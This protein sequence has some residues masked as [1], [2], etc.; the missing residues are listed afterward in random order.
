MHTLSCH[1]IPLEIRKLSFISPSAYE[2]K[3]F[4]HNQALRWL[5]FPRWFP[6]LLKHFLRTQ[7][8]IKSRLWIIC[9]CAFSVSW[10]VTC[11]WMLPRCTLLALC[12]VSLWFSMVTT[13]DTFTEPQVSSNSRMQVSF[14]IYTNY[15]SISFQ[16]PCTFQH[17]NFIKKFCGFRHN[18]FK[19]ENSLLPTKT[20]F[21]MNF[22]ST[23]S[24][25]RWKYFSLKFHQGSPLGIIFVEKGFFPQ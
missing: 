13:E 14:I 18:F 17:G 3:F 1:R 5:C 2:C 16:L 9:L 11:D 4:H 12:V 24:I 15:L 20:H 8:S 10:A 21:Q 23:Q 25:F 6:G 22:T 19:C 7:I